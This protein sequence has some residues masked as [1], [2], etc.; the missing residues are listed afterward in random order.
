MQ[1]TTLR[2]QSRHLAFILTIAIGF[3]SFATLQG[4]ES[5]PAM[6]KSTAWQGQTP[7]SAT[8][9]WGTLEAEL[10]PGVRTES[11]LYAAK[12]ELLRQGHI[13]DKSTASPQGGKLTAL[14]QP[15]APY[16]KVQINTTTQP[17][18]GVKLTINID[19][20]SESRTRLVLDA[21]LNQ[22]GI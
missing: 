4:C 14:S 8:Y 15:G 3:C 1:S 13:I 9:L 7:I 17:S 12:A 5:V 21:I 19:P 2:D 6:R 10:P 22:L 16:K 20:D 18:G 11:V